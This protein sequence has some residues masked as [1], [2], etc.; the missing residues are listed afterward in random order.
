MPGNALSGFGEYITAV[1][2]FFVP[3]HVY[4]RPETFRIGI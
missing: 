3:T 1:D 2:H 4:V